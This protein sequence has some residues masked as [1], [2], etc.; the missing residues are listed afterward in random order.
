MKEQRPSSEC[1]SETLFALLLSQFSP[2][3][4]FSLLLHLKFPTANHAFFLPLFRAEGKSE[5][6]KH[7][8]KKGS[9]LGEWGQS[10][11]EW[12]KWAASCIEIAIQGCK[13]SGCWE[14]FPFQ[15]FQQQPASK[16]EESWD[17]CGS[18]GERG[19]MWT[20]RTLLAGI[21][22]WAERKPC[23]VHWKMGD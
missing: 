18:G 3:T 10:V 9:C 4:H 22:A 7:Q 13:E 16:G 5:Q 6:L 23:L 8:K 20:Y 14:T 19:G 15:H 2:V 1:G 11:N 12:V 21:E 17:M